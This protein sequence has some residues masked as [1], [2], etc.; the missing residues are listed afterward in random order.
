MNRQ[1]DSSPA[2]RVPLA[3]L[4]RCA[5]AIPRLSE[6]LESVLRSGW[7]VHGKECAAFE[8][9]FATY[10]GVAHCVGVANGT[11]A[12]E[13]AMRAIGLGAGARIVTVANAGFYAST[14]MRAI[15]AVPIFVDIERS[16]HLLDVR[17][18]ER[19]LAAGR[20]D[21]IVV[22]HLYGLLA[23]MDTI[24]ALASDGR[25]PIIEDCAQSH[26]ASRGDTKAGAFGDIGC[27]SFYPTKNLGGIGDG[28]AV[29]THDSDVANTLRCLRQYG[30]E[31]KYVVSRAGGRN[32]RLDELQAAILRV[33]LAYLDSWNER[34]REIASRYGTGLKNPRIVKQPSW[35]RDFVAHLYVVEATDRDDLRRHL[36]N[37]GVATDVHYPVPDHLQPISV[38]SARV[39]LPNTEAASDRVLT[40]PCFAEM[41]DTEVDHVIDAVNSW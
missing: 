4:S 5:V 32:S 7:F 10:C 16:S 1:T 15:G 6:S 27:F 8:Q 18:L 9:E 2:M 37:L 38:E 25:I 31:T 20:V 12:L 11:D 34:R 21:A 33:K 40:L 35:G 23:D 29:V 3:D 24:R 39:S 22:T 36:S 30:W 13:L 14:A 17:H 28:G 41:T 26:G 19:I